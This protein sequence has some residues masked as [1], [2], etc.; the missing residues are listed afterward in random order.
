MIPKY[1]GTQARSFKHLK[2][3]RRPEQ[4]FLKRNYTD[5]HKVINKVQ[6]SMKEIQ[7]HD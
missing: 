6:L 5:I 3:R 7:N 4:T 1:V 2:A